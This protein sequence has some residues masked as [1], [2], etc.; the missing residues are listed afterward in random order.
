MHGPLNVK[1]RTVTKQRKDSFERKKKYTQE[2]VDN[3]TCILL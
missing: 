2:G 3:N 1:L